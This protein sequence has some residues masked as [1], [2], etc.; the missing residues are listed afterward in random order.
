MLLNDVI[1][2][3]DINLQWKYSRVVLVYKGGEMSELKNYRLI[4]II[5]VICK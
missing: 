1:D 5:N 3:G 4:A 2:G